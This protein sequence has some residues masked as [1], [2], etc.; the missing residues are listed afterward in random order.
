MTPEQLKKLREEY[1]RLNRELKNL[2][3]SAFKGMSNEPEMA[4]KQI[5][6]LQSSLNAAKREAAGLSDIFGD[7]RASLQAN[8]G[9]LDKASNSINTGKRAYRE[10]VKV[11]RELSDE[12]A[13]INKLSF[14]Q[15]KKL[16]ARNQSS[17][18]EMKLAAERLA[19]ENGFKDA[20]DKNSDTFQN[21]T[22]SEQALLLARQDGFKVEKQAVQFT[23]FRL[24][25]ERKVLDTLKLTGGA[26]QGIG[27]LAQSL[28]LQGFSE[29]INDIKEE[30]EGDLRKKIRKGAE[31]L[32]IATSDQG[33]QY[34]E[35]IT[36][37]KELRDL[38]EDITEEQHEELKG[39]EEANKKHEE[40]IQALYEKVE[41]T[42]NLGVK[43]K[44]VTKAAGE[45]A[46]QLMDPVFFIGSM[47]KGFTE[48]DEKA[49]EF[50]RLTGQN[51][52]ALANQNNQMVLATEVMEMMTGF[53]KEFAVNMAGV[54]TAEQL[55][56]LAE[57][58]K[59]LGLS[60]EQSNRL[61][62]NVAL[63]GKSVNEFEETA[64][65]SAKAVSKNVKGGANLGQVLTDIN[66]TSAAVALSLGNNPQALAKATVQ[67]QRLGM[68]LDQIDGIAS[69]MLDF[70]SSIQAELEAQLLVGKQINL[71]KARE[72]ALNNDLATLSEEILNNNALSND[73]GKSNRIQQ[74]A[75]A[76]ALGMS[77]ED[78][79]KM[80]VIEKLKAGI[81]EEEV[82]RQQG[83]SLEQVKQIT[84]ADKFNTAIGRLKQSLGPLIDAM[85]PIV[86]ILT[87][88]LL[89]ISHAITSVT[90]LGTSIRT[91][92]ERDVKGSIEDALTNLG[93][94]MENSFLGKLLSFVSGGVITIAGLGAGSAMLKF[95]TKGTR[96]NPT[97]VQNKNELGG[98]GGM[99][100]DIKKMNPFKKGGMKNL[101]KGL[102]KGSKGLVK[103]SGILSLVTTGMDLVD[104]LNKAA[105][106]E[107]KG[108]GDALLH[109]LDQNKFMALGAAIGSV[110]PGV[111]TLVGA[112][113]GGLADMFLGEHTMMTEMAKGGIVTKPTKALIGE[114]GPEAVIP[115]S[116]MND[117][118][119]ESLAVKFDQMI[120]KLDA[121]TN[122]K[123]DVYIDGYKAGQSIFAASNNLPS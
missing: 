11:V 12:E 64:L 82:A 4:A 46:K 78:L 106:S 58:T 114:A 98:G 112:G 110:V 9:E 2:T 17:L 111:G 19:I 69:S 21:L 13:G 96:A 51:V 94:K 75:M 90:K 26:L 47:V 74:E 23:G 25:L 103:G 123:G 92:F 53:S 119:V 40:G 43:L 97:I 20:L 41:V 101:G 48:L 73:F 117:N 31:E 6:T 67:A 118:T 109:T 79:A 71:G 62:S 10:L 120:E 54:F 30:L 49:V 93:E 65:A 72:A 33:E 95:F 15:L 102:L 105:E 122:I 84:A 68:N 121:L 85:V 42:N 18:D 14:Q 38:G 116:T 56:E 24:N 27:N 5:K 8:V 115:L 86:D 34:A 59:L 35:N 29:S 32:Y 113:I 7:L 60:A 44:A 107:D 76:K 1:N 88:A 63:S 104:N 81:S 61:A 52:K 22:E 100:K 108:V 87:S 50:Q 28:G 80:I 3:G 66:S 57:S 55:G 91:I 37:I 36:K 77:R 39:L 89:P 99:F 16:K 70:E 83:L 45:F